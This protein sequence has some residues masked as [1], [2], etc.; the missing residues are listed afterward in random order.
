M[1]MVDSVPAGVLRWLN[2]FAVHTSQFIN[3]QFLLG[4]PNET[5]SARAWRNRHKRLGAIAVAILDRVFFWEDNHC[6][7]SHVEDLLFAKSLMKDDN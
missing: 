6:M 7:N 1:V 2:N 4:H 3:S 5:V